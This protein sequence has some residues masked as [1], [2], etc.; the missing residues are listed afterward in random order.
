MLEGGDD[1][2]A[3]GDDPTATTTQAI[4]NCPAWICGSNDPEVN[5][6]GVGDV[7]YHELNVNGVPNDE[8]FSLL[9]L[10]SGP[11]MYKAVVI[12]GHLR[13]KKPGFADIF[14]AGLVGTTLVVK[15]NKAGVVKI[16]NYSIDD[17]GT[18]SLYPAG[19]GAGETP[20]Y[21][22]SYTVQGQMMNPTPMCSDP[23]S[24]VGEYD[25]LWQDPFTVVLFEGD[26]WWEGSKTYRGYDTDWF[27]IGCAGH[28]L[29]KLDLTYHS[30]VTSGASPGKTTSV[31]Q[32]QAMLKMYS[33]DYCGDGT[34]FTVSG[35]ELGWK[36]A[37]APY[38]YAIAGLT[39]EARWNA[40]GP[41]CLEEPRL[42][43]TAD[44]LALQLF[45]PNI[46]TAI[47]NHCGATRPPK[48]SDLGQLTDVTLNYGNWIVSANP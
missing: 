44:P 32:R 34:S 26:R 19:P 37:Y 23:T 24:L 12:N 27:N 18:T 13:G 39:L 40:T 28:V 2:S 46:D 33:A 22:L 48:C 35:T 10:K 7:A 41:Q 17:V 36:N 38:Y 5:I 20:T 47:N 31:N 43:G 14:G 45:G 25:T 3:S 1:G 29:S 8:G 16:V 4:I 15:Y 30:S 11:T 42:T 6:F 21:T 9:G